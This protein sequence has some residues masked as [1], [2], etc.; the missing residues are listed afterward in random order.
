VQVNKLQVDR[1][2]VI[3]RVASNRREPE[4]KNAIGIGVTVT[5]DN[6]T[7]AGAVVAGGAKVL[8]GIEPDPDQGLKREGAGRG[9]G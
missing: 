5:A 7:W 2:V 9:I 4:L 3:G 6:L 1:D 8:A